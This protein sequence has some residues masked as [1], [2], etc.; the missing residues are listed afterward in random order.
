MEDQRL[1]GK[2]GERTKHDD[3]EDLLIVNR[4]LIEFEKESSNTNHSLYTPTPQKR[5][6][7]LQFVYLRIL[8]LDFVVHT[9]S[10]DGGNPYHVTLALDNSRNF[11]AIILVKSFCVSDLGSQVVQD[12]F[13]EN[14]SE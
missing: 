9:L 3:L 10:R 1:G 6:L 11:L 2:D 8:P 13:C 4:E 12:A 5:Q 7:R 14:Q